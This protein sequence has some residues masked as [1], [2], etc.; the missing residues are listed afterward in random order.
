MCVCMSEATSSLNVSV[1]MDRYVCVYIY[2]CMSE[3]TSSLN[4]SVLMD[5]YVCV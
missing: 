3:A 5:R 1:L 4:V 2:V